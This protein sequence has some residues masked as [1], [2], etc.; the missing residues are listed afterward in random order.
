MLELSPE[1]ES[2]IAEI[3][4]REIARQESTPRETYLTV[5][6]VAT[7]LNCH[8]DTILRRIHSLQIKSIGKGKLLRVPESAVRHG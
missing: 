7:R 8:P 4:R 1:I 5:K 3:V 6:E 2:C